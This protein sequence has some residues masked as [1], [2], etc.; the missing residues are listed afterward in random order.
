M[1]DF[2]QGWRWAAVLLGLS[3]ALSGCTYAAIQKLS[4]D[5]RAEFH[6]YKKVM[7]AAQERTYLARASA[8]R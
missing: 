1:R 4:P 6:I 3:V 7:S 5:E 8:P 2:R